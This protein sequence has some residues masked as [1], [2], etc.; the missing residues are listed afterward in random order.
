MANDHSLV[1]DW[2]ESE[3]RGSLATDIDTAWGVLFAL[4]NGTGIRGK[5]FW[6]DVLSNGCETFTAAEV[7]Q[8]AQQLKAWDEQRLLADLAG[9]KE[10]KYRLEQYQ[11]DPQSLLAQFRNLRSFYEQAAARG[12]AAINYVA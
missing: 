10:D 2:T 5:D 9:L 11:S 3:D 6:D 12:L 8:C 4:L 1:D 7:A